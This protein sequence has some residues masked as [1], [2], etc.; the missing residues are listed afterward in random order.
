V[1]YPVGIVLALIV[2][3]AV[4]WLL[5]VS[6]TFLGSPPWLAEASAGFFAA[7]AFIL[8]GAHVAASR[9]LAFPLLLF[10]IGAS[11]S[12]FLL[13]GIVG[14]ISPYQG[15]LELACTYVGGGVGV[16]LFLKHVRRQVG[17]ARLA[18]LAFVV[19]AAIFGASAEALLRPQYG[20]GGFVYGPNGEIQPVRFVW[21]DRHASA[22][23]W[24]PNANA[25]LLTK[26]AE[27]GWIE[28]ET[29]PGSGP[30][31]ASTTEIRDSED[32]HRTRVVAEASMAER[33]KW[34]RA[35]GF[36]P[37]FL[38]FRYRAMQLPSGPVLR[39]EM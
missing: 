23:I 35:H 25:S 7:A 1:L 27:S 24:T 13:R 12:W 4:S 5:V 22:A 14:D 21:L 39:A 3:L 2:S 6:F 9:G 29:D 11:F 20:N 10:A 37:A 26:A 28:I 17:R 36:V 19:A 38:T 33:I 18:A 34:H 15:V 31:S 30:L 8:V 16:F 32:L